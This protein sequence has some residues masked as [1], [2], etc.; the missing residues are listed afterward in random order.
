MIPKQ[1]VSIF[2]SWNTFKDAIAFYGVMALMCY[3]IGIFSM[4]C[5]LIY[6]Q[7]SLVEYMRCQE[8]ARAGYPVSK[9][10]NLSIE[11]WF[12]HVFGEPRLNLRCFVPGIQPKSMDLASEKYLEKAK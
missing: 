5:Y 7:S 8:S 2:Y 6:I 4:V 11:E 1:N 9:W 3:T 12:Q 10:R